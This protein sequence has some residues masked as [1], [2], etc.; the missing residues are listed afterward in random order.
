MIFII[1][2]LSCIKLKALVYTES[3]RFL[4]NSEPSPRL[5]SLNEG[6]GGAG[7][8]I[9]ISPSSG[10]LQKGWFYLYLFISRLKLRITCPR[11]Q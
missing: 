2:T 7:V 1:L 5:L 10:S 11:L 4:Q 8:C 6:I 9:L 3:S